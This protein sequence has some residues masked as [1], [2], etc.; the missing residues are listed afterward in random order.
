MA[1]VFVEA[2]PKGQQ[3]RIPITASAATS[4][5]PGAPHDLRARDRTTCAS[6]PHLDGR[7]SGGVALKLCRPTNL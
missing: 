4:S 6:R 7:P 3:E 1:N 2:R 5:E